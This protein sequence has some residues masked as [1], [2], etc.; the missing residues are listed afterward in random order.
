MAANFGDY[1]TLLLRD[2]GLK[3]EALYD[4]LLNRQP[5]PRRFRTVS[6]LKEHF[7]LLRVHSAPAIDFPYIHLI[8]DFFDSRN[9][10]AAADRLRHICSQQ[11]HDSTQ[12]TLADQGTDPLDWL[13]HPS[14]SAHTDLQSLV[15]LIEK[16]KSGDKSLL[17]RTLEFYLSSAENVVHAP[18]RQLIAPELARTAI[19]QGDYRSAFLVSSTYIAAW[20]QRRQS[21]SSDYVLRERDLF[22]YLRMLQIRATAISFIFYPSPALAS[23]DLFMEARSELRL[24]RSLF[25][26]STSTYHLLGQLYLIHWTRMLCRA[27]MA[28]PA[29]DLASAPSLPSLHKSLSAATRRILLFTN[30]VEPLFQGDLFT[31]YDTLA[32][33]TALLAT[34]PAELDQASKLHLLSASVA[35]SRD[36]RFRTSDV[37]RD[38]RLKSTLAILEIS[39]FRISND[40]AT[41]HLAS[42][43]LH[44]VCM[45]VPFGMQRHVAHTFQQLHL[46]AYYCCRDSR[47]FGSHSCT[48]KEIVRSM[49]EL[50]GDIAFTRQDKIFTVDPAS[51]DHLSCLIQSN[52]LKRN[53]DGFLS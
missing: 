24:H 1:L 53:D 45:S 20:H 44:D 34:S 48:P 38:F 16:L 42:D 40:D 29:H 39:K 7:R 36:Y 18:L 13:I 11:H 49:D 9:L 52:L 28:L 27:I 43:S 3:Q 50:I 47:P 5:A 10:G 14:I 6:G 23:R 37:L 33:A 15:Q 26:R 12:S 31:L 35:Y 21:S 51:P 19:N 17:A 32:R 8:A 22:D 25:R 41:R 2:A 46:Y 4:W 30:S